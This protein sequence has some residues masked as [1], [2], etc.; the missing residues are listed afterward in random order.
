MKNILSSYKQYR[1]AGGTTEVKRVE[2][3]RVAN[4]FNKHMIGL[5]FEGN[6]V[7]VPERLG[8]IIVKGKKVETE[9]DEELGRISNQSIDFGETNKLWAKC[10]DCEE[11]KQ[12]VYHLNEH[13]N[14]VRYRYF[15]SR[16]RVLVENK[17]FYTMR[18]TRANKRG[19]SKL[20]KSG[21]EFYIEPKK[22]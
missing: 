20:I 19:L 13:T 8:T 10:P 21:T 1:E 18:F 6:E 7:K 2:F 4:D 5:V 11:R 3:C 9:F 14:G 16:D 22:Y 17:M 12:M 15:W